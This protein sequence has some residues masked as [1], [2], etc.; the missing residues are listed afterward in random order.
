MS[1]L[2]LHD[3]GLSGVEGAQI[4]LDS[5][6]PDIVE[7]S[8]GHNRLGS[9][10]CSYLFQALTA[11]KAD[12]GS[13]V[14]DRN[15]E[16]VTVPPRL[17]GFRG[18]AKIT[19]SANG[20]DED[21]LELISEYLEGDECL[22][23]LYFTNNLISG[24]DNLRRLGKA[25]ARSKLEVISFNTNP[26]SADGLREFLSGL[27][28]VDED[29]TSDVETS[30]THAR[31]RWR[32]SITQTK[33]H[34][35][36]QLHLSSCPLG[37]DGA[38]LIA[39][40]ISHPERSA[41][42]NVLTLNDCELGLRGL[43]IVTRAAEIWNFTLLIME[44]HL[45]FSVATELDPYQRI[46][47]GQGISPEL[48]NELD[49]L[50]DDEQMIDQGFSF[51][52]KTK[53]DRSRYRRPAFPIDRKKRS[54]TNLLQV[55][56]SGHGDDPYI[57]AARREGIRRGLRHHLST[58]ESEVIKR[59]TLMREAGQK[60]ALQAIPVA[61]VLLTGRAP[62]PADVGADIMESMMQK[63]P[64]SHLLCGSSN[65]PHLRFPIMDLPFD[66]VPNIIQQSTDSPHSLS[67]LQWESLYRY[68][69]SRETLHAEMEKLAASRQSRQ[70]TFVIST[71]PTRT[72]TGSG[73]SSYRPGPG[74]PGR[75]EWLKSLAFG[76]TSQ[77]KLMPQEEKAVMIG[78]LDEIGC[79]SW[80]WRQQPNA[81]VYTV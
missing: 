54:I 2:F 56:T 31:S 63:P 46:M 70:E 55:L 42:L 58:R 44:T 62:N 68:A 81:D 26:L 80:D 61:R 35:L 40:F 71:S 36:K 66:V 76:M 21:A 37:L 13:S 27:S 32:H 38:R 20:V 18:L 22:R 53:I 12:S 24:P 69:E 60:T 41:N 11:A 10:G 9:S 8:V 45:N 19:L 29:W 16:S 28:E 64:S 5:M 3:Q 67:D 6:N 43:N 51:Q 4:I 39:D 30:R 34:C 17:S 23:E 25:V 47:P 65:S 74:H 52:T 72:L 77:G 33:G 1:E 14:Y 15:S 59:N 50:I 79:N 7:L 75:S 57:Q 78:I 49:E 48:Q 73:L